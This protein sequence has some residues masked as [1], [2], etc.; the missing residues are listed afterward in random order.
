MQQA[1]EK[2]SEMASAEDVK[3]A[4]GTIGN[5]VKRAVEFE[6]VE[7]LGLNLEKG[8]ERIVKEPSTVNEWVGDLNLDEVRKSADHAVERVKAAAHMAKDKLGDLAHRAEQ[9]VERTMQSSNATGAAG[10]ADI[11]S[12]VKAKAEAA[13]G[14]LKQKG[15]EVKEKVKAGVSEA[16][17]E[18]I[19]D[20][21]NPDRI[22]VAVKSVKKQAAEA[23]KSHDA[24]FKEEHIRKGD[25]A[26]LHVAPSPLLPTPPAS[27]QRQQ[28][29]G[30]DPKQPQYGTRVTSSGHHPQHHKGEGMASAYRKHLGGMADTGEPGIHGEEQHTTGEAQQ[31][32]Q[33]AHQQQQQPQEPESAPRKRYKSQFHGASAG[34]R[35][36]TETDSNFATSVVDDID[37]DEAKEMLHQMMPGMASTADSLRYAKKGIPPLAPEVPFLKKHGMISSDQNGTNTHVVGT[38][39]GSESDIKQKAKWSPYHQHKRTLFTCAK[40][41]WAES[42]RNPI[43]RRKFA[44]VPGVGSFGNNVVKQSS[45]DK[46]TPSM[47]AL[48]DVSSASETAG[49]KKNEET[50]DHIRYEDLEFDDRVESLGMEPP[51]QNW[52]TDMIQHSVADAE[53]EANSMVHDLSKKTQAARKHLRK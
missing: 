29:T 37:V 26:E 13:T 11:G 39:I 12:S 50:F 5:A 48:G 35:G 46:M 16:V 2:G 25:A 10:A 8:P 47:D 3:G 14:K 21:F 49:V 22:A 51:E 1:K 44:D 43:F 15:K 18:D 38:E 52:E 53:K 45:Q 6:F 17:P 31:T 28:Q 23:A 4:A 19:P 20:E 9:A 27:S 36:P 32:Q 33:Q 41:N 34:Q 24:F 7:P 42:Y 30:F 40:G